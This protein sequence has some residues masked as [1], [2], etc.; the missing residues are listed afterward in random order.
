MFWSSRW[1]IFFSWSSSWRFRISGSL[2]SYL[3]NF[4][5]LAI[6]K[7]V[8][9]ELGWRPRR[10]SSTFS[11]PRWQEDKV[12]RFNF[13]F[14]IVS[15]EVL[16]KRLAPV[17][18]GQSLMRLLRQS[19]LLIEVLQSRSFL[20]F[21]LGKVF[22]K[23]PWDIIADVDALNAKTFIGEDHCSVVL[24]SLP[25]SYSSFQDILFYDTQEFSLETYEALFSKESMSKFSTISFWTLV[26]GLVVKERDQEEKIYQILE[27]IRNYCKKKEHIN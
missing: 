5:V 4:F 10:L 26:E 15:S 12:H 21:I 13:I 23:I 22:Y 6:I 20:V 3:K 19:Q 18:F 9:L 14:H 8:V 1:S 16:A 25:S 2:F 24:M 27:N 11:G 17:C 7:Q